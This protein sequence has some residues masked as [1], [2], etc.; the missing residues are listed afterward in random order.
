MQQLHYFQMP[1]AVEW[2]QEHGVVA[3][4]WVTQR[5]LM[6]VMEAHTEIFL[7]M[8]CA[9]VHLQLHV[10]VAPDLAE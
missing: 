7:L 2:G 4:R 6:E 10:V 3:Q 5:V 1:M 8:E 9:V